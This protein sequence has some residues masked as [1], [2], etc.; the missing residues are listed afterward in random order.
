[1]KRCSRKLGGSTK[2]PVNPGSRNPLRHDFLVVS[3]TIYS[4]QA[5][6]GFLGMLRSQGRIDNNENLNN[7]CVTICDDDSF[8][9]YV[10]EAVNEVGAPTYCVGAYPGTPE[11]KAGARNCQTWANE[12]IHIARKNYLKA[13]VNSCPRC[14]GN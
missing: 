4:F 9:Q 10:R 13:S 5:G 12:V 3:G 11:F 6:G 2:P 1:V 14:F 8:D 7:K